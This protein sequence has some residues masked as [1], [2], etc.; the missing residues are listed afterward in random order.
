MLQSS[1]LYALC[2]YGLLE[3]FGLSLE[4]F[5]EIA[6]RFDAAIVQYRDK[7]GSFERKQENIR[8]LRSLWPKTLIVNDEIGLV[9][10]CDG[11]HIGQEDLAQLMRSFGTESKLQGIALLRKMVGKK[12]IGLSTHNQAEI[13][14]A[15]ELDL[16]YVGLG[17]Y[18]H[19][20]TKEVQSA[21]GERLGVIAALSRHPV[22]AI[23][24]VGLFEHIPNVAYRAIGS[25]LVIKALTYA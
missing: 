14:E 11:L 16:D 20:R 9:Q 23:G 2:D 21:L 8:K 5:V 25:D 12:I 24:G 4:D 10:F 3:R 6:R 13:L 19:S 1:K 17:A 7:E 15:N 22:A 18:R